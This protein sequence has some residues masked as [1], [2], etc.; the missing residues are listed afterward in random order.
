MYY[1]NI[2]QNIIVEQHVDHIIVSMDDYQLLLYLSNNVTNI[3]D[4][5][6]V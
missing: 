1:Y 5:I 4:Q 3:D 2:L 6:Y